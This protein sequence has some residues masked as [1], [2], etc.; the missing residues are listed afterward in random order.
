[1]EQ[2]IGRQ[3]EQAIQLIAQARPGNRRLEPG[4]PRGH[5]EARGHHLE[6]LGNLTRRARA[7]AFAHQ[8]GR[9]R[10]QAAL[11]VRDRST[12]PRQE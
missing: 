9:E 1:M 5:G 8:R 11:I 4:N 12:R 10:R 3:I 2:H 6:L 7:R